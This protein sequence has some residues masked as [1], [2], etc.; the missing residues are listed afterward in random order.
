VESV[1]VVIWPVMDENG[2]E[3]D[4]ACTVVPIRECHLF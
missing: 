3:M 4:I 2:R 1:S